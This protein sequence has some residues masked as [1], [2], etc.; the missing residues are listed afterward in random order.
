MLNFILVYTHFSFI[1]FPK[2]KKGERRGKGRGSREEE[3]MGGEKT[4]I[5]F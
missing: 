5:F 1:V 2:E 4:K 3:E